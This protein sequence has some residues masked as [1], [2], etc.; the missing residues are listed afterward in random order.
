MLIPSKQAEFGIISDIDDT[1]LHTG[2]VSTLKWR[3]IY[4]TV[5]IEGAILANCH[6]YLVIR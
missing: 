3:V 1:I 6:R 5:F 2:L 4:N